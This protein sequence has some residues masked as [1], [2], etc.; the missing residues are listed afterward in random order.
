MGHVETE[1]PCPALSR[2][3]A[4]PGTPGCMDALPACVPAAWRGLGTE[5]QR[6]E[7]ELGVPPQGRGGCA[8]PGL[9]WLS[10]L[11]LTA[12]VSPSCSVDEHG[13]LAALG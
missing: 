5:A 8:W 9:S 10:P 6:V 7:A 13:L 1:V 4:G 2:R 11:S 12:S 3:R